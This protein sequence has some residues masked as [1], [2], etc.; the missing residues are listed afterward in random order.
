MTLIAPQLAGLVA[1]AGVAYL[2]TVAGVGKHV[3]EW[4]RSSR[5]CPSCGRHIDARVCGRCAG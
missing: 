2:M 1:A 4:R 5:R 3:L